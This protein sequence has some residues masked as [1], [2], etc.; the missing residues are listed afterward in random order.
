MRR[1]IRFFKW[2]LGR[3]PKGSDATGKML[4]SIG[5]HVPPIK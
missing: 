3:P 5:R 1:V 2:L 4:D